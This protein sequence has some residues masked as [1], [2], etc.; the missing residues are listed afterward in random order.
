MDDGDSVL[1]TGGGLTGCCYFDYVERYNMDGLVE[2]LPS[3]KVARWYHACTK[4]QVRSNIAKIILTNREF[5]F[6]T[7]GFNFF[8][9]IQMARRFTWW[10]EASLLEDRLTPLRFSRRETPPGGLLRGLSLAVVL[11]SQSTTFLICLVI[12]LN[13]S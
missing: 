7:K 6:S 5:L 9:R 12:T 3:L 13:K 8:I 1:I 11:L 4:Y 10:S 2:T